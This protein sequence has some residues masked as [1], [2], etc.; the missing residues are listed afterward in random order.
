ME[1]P[2]IIIVITAYMYL[3]DWV[4]AGA[5]E[6]LHQ[7]YTVHYVA[8]RS[9]WDPREFE[10]YGIPQYRVISQPGYRQFLL[11]RLLTVTMYKHARMSRAFRIKLDLVRPKTRFLYRALSLP[12]LYDLLLWAYNRLLPK[13][14][15]FSDLVRDVRPVLVLAPSLAADSYTIDM[16]YSARRLGIKSLMLINSWD[17]LVS[18]GVLPIP[19]DSLAVWGPQGVNQATHVQKVP[20]DRIVQLGVPRF[21]SYFD[22]RQTTPTA[23]IHSFNR[24]PEGKKV[25]LYATT[26]M[27]FDDIQALKLLD[28]EISSAYPDYVILFRPHPGMQR[29]VGEVNATECGFRNVYIDQQLAGYYAARFTLQTGNYPS[30]DAPLDYYPAL[31]KSVVGMICPPTTLSLE[32]ALN[33][34]PCLM[35]CYGDGRNKWLS[36]DLVSQYENVEEVLQFPGVVPCYSETELLSCFQRIVECSKDDELRRRLVE[37]TRYVVYRDEKPYD[38]RLCNLVDNLLIAEAS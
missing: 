32:G 18:K 6:A 23:Q 22:D 37:A 2:H 24:I 36:P 33:G 4:K 14:T 3:R 10:K 26:S 12:G 7:H 29:R 35:I 5:F 17:N 38:R 19:P 34:V 9:D 15:E 16:T 11:R 31:M 8:V 28:Q 30:F 21:E 25:I 27:P 20:R 13:W 1:K